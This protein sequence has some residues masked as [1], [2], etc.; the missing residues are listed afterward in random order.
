MIHFFRTIAFLLVIVAT[1]ALGRTNII[2]TAPLSEAS[3]ANVNIADEI[4]SV[5]QQ[6]RRD[7]GFQGSIIITQHGNLL[8]RAS[9][10][11]ADIANKTI[12]EIDTAFLIGSLTKSFTAIT[13]LQLVEEGKLDLYAPITRYIPELA[14]HLAKDLNLHLLLKQQTGFPMHLERLTELQN[15]AISSDDILQIINTATM[16]FASGERYEYSNLNYHLA[17][18][19]IER[20]TGKS[21]AQVLQERSFDPLHMKRSGIERFGQRATRRANGYFKEGKEITHAENNV[22]Y[23]LGSGDIYST[24]DDLLLWDQALKGE[25]YLSA[26]SKKLLFS[27]ESEALGYYGYG[28]RIQPYQRA[29]TETPHGQLIRHGGSMNGFLSNYH[30]YVE[31]DLTIIVLGNIR[32]FSIRNMTYQLKEAALQSLRPRSGELE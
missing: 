16:A 14:P 3:K 9:Y 10:G 7:E 17:A 15:K 28:F 11:Y 18:I 29:S 21:Y 1:N 22:S 26:P 25:A 5:V 2:N 8:L 32:P 19:A 13:V 27:G 24:V 31:D 20:V 12:N 30:H 4:E 6:Y 23:A